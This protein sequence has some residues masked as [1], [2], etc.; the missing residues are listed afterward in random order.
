MTRVE[1]I[2]TIMCISFS[3]FACSNNPINNSE[4]ALN[5]EMCSFDQINVIVDALSNSE[6]FLTS[7]FHLNQIEID[8]FTKTDSRLIKKQIREEIMLKFLSRL[9]DLSP[10][11]ID[12]KPKYTDNLL[13]SDM[14][15]YCLA[16]IELMPFA[17]ATGGQNCTEKL[18]SNEI[19]LPVNFTIFSDRDQI[20]YS[21]L[22]YFCS[23]FREQ[24][25]K[26]NGYD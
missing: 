1:I 12:C 9:S 8:L 26:E 24:Y 17:Q 15:L 21:Y 22:K 10:I 25:L 20:T 7:T 14:S 23:N 18:I 4:Q 3:I 13:I 19:N 2:V 11:E 5:R 16:K 6:Y